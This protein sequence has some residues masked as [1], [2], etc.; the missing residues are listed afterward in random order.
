MRSA[1]FVSNRSKKTLKDRA[2]ADKPPVRALDLVHDG[3]CML[4][5]FLWQSGVHKIILAQKAET[6]AVARVFSLRQLNIMT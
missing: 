4:L 5:H 2:P 6:R 3:V 1:E